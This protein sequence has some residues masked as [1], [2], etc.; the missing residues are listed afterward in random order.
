M[1]AIMAMAKN[2]A[3][4]NKGQLPWEGKHKEDFVWFKEF[5]MGK[6]LIVGRKTFDDLPPLKG[7]GIYIMTKNIWKKMMIQSATNS[8]GLIG[9]KVDFDFI[10]DYDDKTDFIIA[11][12]KSIYELFMPHITEFYVTHI[13]KEYEGDTFMSP[14]EHLFSSQKVVKTFDFGKV[15]C[16]NK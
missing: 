13:D 12:G 10:M 15:V 5:T 16:Y 7:R 6:I 4:G 9:R 11:G 14:F 1:K 8:L 2:R 3:I